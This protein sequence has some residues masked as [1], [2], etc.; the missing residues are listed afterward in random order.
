MFSYQ[1]YLSDAKKSISTQL[2]RENALYA[3]FFC[4]DEYIEKIITQLQIEYPHCSVGKSESMIMVMG[5]E[6]HC[7]QYAVKQI[8]EFGVKTLKLPDVYIEFCLNKL[9]DNFPDK[10]FKIETSRQI[11][12]RDKYIVVD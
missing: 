8:A 2:N 4:V 3:F 9:R 12:F 1:E 5:D 6:N 7:Y 10:K 11:Y